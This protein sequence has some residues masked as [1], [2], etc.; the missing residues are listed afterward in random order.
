M[1][2]SP[3]I[4][5]SVIGRRPVLGGL[6]AL[7]VAV[8]TYYGVLFVLAQYVQQGLR[9]SALAPGLALIPWVA[10]FG[11]AGQVYRFLPRQPPF[12]W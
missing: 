2:R 11:V 4:D 6:I 3:L 1:R 12:R 8:S 7:I 10:A 5:V 9:E